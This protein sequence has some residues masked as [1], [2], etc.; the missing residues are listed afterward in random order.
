MSILIKSIETNNVRGRNVIL[1]ADLKSEVPTT[2]AATIAAVGEDVKLN[3]G[4]VIYTAALEAAILDTNDEWDWDFGGGGSSGDVTSVN[5]KTGAVVLNAADVGAG[6]YTKPSDGI[7]ASDLASGVIPET[8]V[9][10]YRVSDLSSGVN[11]TCDKTFAEVAAAIQAK[12]PLIAY[13]LL[14]NTVIGV[15]TSARFDGAA[16]FSISGSSALTNELQVFDIIHSSDSS[17]LYLVAQSP[18]SATPQALGTAAAGSST[19][20]S[21]ADH[22][23]AM[24]TA[25]DVGAIPAVTE[26]TV[27]TAGA[28]TQALDAGKMYH[29][30]GA[31]TSL[32]LTL[33]TAASG[34]LAQ[35]HLDFVEGSTAFDPVLPN[36]V[37]LPDNH[38][39]EADTRYEV[40]ILNNY[41][42]VVGWAVSA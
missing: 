41:A 32:T 22:V 42:V 39:W 34:Q 36:G 11:A 38:T 37:V 9:V 23:H 17:K 31:L 21:R 8:F 27:S 19:D 16:Y 13:L 4:D 28:V 29:F 7:P 40:D 1:F 2:G 26:V 15:S 6:T 25:V 24:P 20:Y 3:A 33:N 35:Y 14:L 30:T 10:N 5:G 12:T 18:S